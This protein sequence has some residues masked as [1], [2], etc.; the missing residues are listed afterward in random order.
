MRPPVAILDSGEE[1]RS[2]RRA[3]IQEVRGQK[4]RKDQVSDFPCS[5]G[6]CHVNG[7]YLFQKLKTKERHHSRTKEWTLRKRELSVTLKKYGKASGSYHARHAVSEPVVGV[8]HPRVMRI[9]FSQP[10]WD[11]AETR[12]TVD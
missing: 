10:M 4:V 8:A 2:V 1:T 11:M 5:L 9:S 12:F 7:K 6:R 3:R